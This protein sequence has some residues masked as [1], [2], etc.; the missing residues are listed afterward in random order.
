MGGMSLKGKLF[1]LMGIPV[2]AL[3]LLAGYEMVDRFMSYRNTSRIIDL[4]QLAQKASD[5]VHENQKERGFTAGFLSSA[6]QNFASELSSQTG[7][8]DKKVADLRSFLKGFDVAQFGGEFSA[9]LN[10]GMSML[11]QHATI[12]QQVRAQTIN[13]ATAIG[14]YTGINKAFLNMIAQLPHFSDSAD[15]ANELSQFEIFLQSKERAGV[16]RAVLANVFGADSFKGRE[17]L[18]RR[19]VELV[20]A[21]DSYDDVFQAMAGSKLQAF[22]NGKKGDESFKITEEMRKKALDGRDAATLGVNAEDWFK[23]QTRKINILKDIE[24]HIVDEMIEDA[25]EHA[26]ESLVFLTTLGLIIL[27][28]LVVIVIFSLIMTNRITESINTVLDKLNQVAS[29]TLT[30]SNQVASSSE[31]L[32]EG[33]SEQAASLEESSS[34]MEELA[35]MTRQNADNAKNAD[36]LAREASKQSENGIQAMKDMLSAI[37][38]IKT[39]SDETAKIIKSI[40]EIAFQTNLLALN[41]AV[42]AARAGEAGKGFAVVAEEVRNLAQRSADAARTTSAMIEDSQTKSDAGVQSARN[43]QNVLESVNSAIQEV[44]VLLQEVSA[45]SNEQAQGAEQVNAGLGQMDQVTQSNAANAEEN[46][47]ASQE[48]SS[49]ADELN[50]SMHSLEEIIFGKNHTSSEKLAGLLADNG[51]TRGS[52]AASKPRPA[53]YTTN[54]KPV[55]QAPQRKSLKDKI[56]MDQMDE[57]HLSNSADMDSF[58][59][60]DFEEIK[61]N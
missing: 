45:A 9:Q 14:F 23:A 52:R 15:I 11:E 47:S 35:N 41:A 16:E 49:L 42:E 28:I 30:A 2:L 48:L 13:S 18:Y 50:K 8:T 31:L 60:S 27:A 20:S 32:A 56:Q 10:S 58:D 53:S 54:F 5:M 38:T 43:V 61:S 21:Q 39:S 44:G 33:S 51:G 19:L 36:G 17:G 29:Q 46:A 59:D 37:N 4:V 1:L 55:A 12:R 22:V 25:G 7:N 26:N 40:D 57:P 6:G 3:V 34:T 24:N